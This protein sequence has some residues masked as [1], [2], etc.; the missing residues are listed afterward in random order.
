MPYPGGPHKNP[1]VPFHREDL[2]LKKGEKVEKVFFVDMDG[3]LLL[4][5]GHIKNQ[6]AQTAL[7]RAFESPKYDYFRKKLDPKLYAGFFDFLE[8]ANTQFHRRYVEEEHGLKAHLYYH[9]KKVLSQE[10]AQEISNALHP[11]VYNEYVKERKELTEPFEKM[12]KILAAIKKRGIKCILFTSR[13]PD[14]T[15]SL[16]KEYDIEQHLDGALFIAAAPKKPLAF[17][18]PVAYMGG[19]SKIN[20]L[21][22]LVK[23]YD[24][25]GNLPNI[26]FIDDSHSFHKKISELSKIHGPISVFKVDAHKNEG[27]DEIISMLK[28]LPWAK[29]PKLPP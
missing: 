9:L 6:A 25:N 16:L 8:K 26:A 2:G 13:S 19:V 17:K 12:H 15:E 11:V 1:R 28:R 3:V 29:N 20:A 22:Q 18:I 7:K 27:F 14:Q 10:K 24:S 21:K 5:E 23:K 4:S